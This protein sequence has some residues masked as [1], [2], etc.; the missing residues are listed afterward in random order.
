[1]AS[2]NEAST[3]YRLRQRG[4]LPQLPRCP[5]CGGRCRREFPG[6]LCAACFSLTP[7]GKEEQRRR[8]RQRVRDHRIRRVVAEHQ[9]AEPDPDREARTRRI[10]GATA[11]HQQADSLAADAAP[12]PTEE[13]P[14]PEALAGLVVRLA[15]ALEEW[16]QGGAPPEPED[17][18][19]ADLIREARAAAMKVLQ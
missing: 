17:T 7:E 11:E 18:A 12:R 8:V 4:K 14:T 19:D 3:R 1:M 10:A 15:D 13:A 9:Q 2:D 6:G 16:Q 5:S